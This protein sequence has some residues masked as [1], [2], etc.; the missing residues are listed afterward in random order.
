MSS[1]EGPAPAAISGESK[2]ESGAPAAVIPENTRFALSQADRL[3]NLASGAATTFL[4]GG[5]AAVVLALFPLRLAD[6][7]WQLGVLNNLVANGSWI[8]V[9]LVL[10][11]LA[12]MLQP[13]NRALSQRL[14]LWR[15]LAALAAVGYMLIVPLQVAIT[16]IGVD[17]SRNTRERVISKSGIQLKSYRDALMGAAN[18][19]DLKA[20]LGAIPGAPPLPEQASLVPYQVVRE[21]LL[22]QLEQAETRF[23]QQVQTVRPGPSALQLWGQI[24][25]GA[26]ASLMLALG[27]ASGAEGLFGQASLLESLKLLL[28]RASNKPAKG[29]RLKGL[30]NPF[31]WIKQRLNLPK[32]SA[33]RPISKPQRLARFRPLQL[34]IH[35][36]WQSWRKRFR[37]KKKGPS[38]QRNRVPH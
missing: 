20:R 24:A 8:L 11:H 37:R 26:V 27:F 31:Q 7:Q 17:A 12:S 10:L 9:G 19:T 22:E 25:R 32:R 2:P 1:A 23:R 4:I 28:R 34:K 29:R 5:V 6:R 15:R 18:L 14:M 21:R 3:A 13:M 33:I 16:W 36:Q 35:R 38:R 30:P